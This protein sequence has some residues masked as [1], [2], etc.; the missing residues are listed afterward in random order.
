MP[1]LYSRRLQSP[2]RALAQVPARPATIPATT[3]AATLHPILQAKLRIGAPDDQYE[4]EADRLADQVMHEPRRVHGVPLNSPNGT[5]AVR[6]KCVSCASSDTALCPE[7]EEELQRQVSPLMARKP[8]GGAVQSVPQIVNNVLSSNGQPLEAATRAYFEGRFGHD[9]STTRVHADAR[10][11]ESARAVGARAYTVGPHVVFG[12]GEYT[13]ETPAGMRLL[14]HELTHV[15]QQQGAQMEASGVMQRSPSVCTEKFPQEDKIFGGE[16]TKET[17]G[18]RPLKL[19]STGQADPTTVN[20]F[21]ATGLRGYPELQQIL[22]D[23]NLNFDIKS[24][25]DAKDCSPGSGLRFAYDPVANKIGLEAVEFCQKGDYLYFKFVCVAPPV[26][27]EVGQQLVIKEQENSVQVFDPTGTRLG[28]GYIQSGYIVMKIRTE[29]TSVTGGGVFD[30]IYDKLKAKG[31]TIKGVAGVWTSEPG[32]EKNLADFNKAIAA[33]ESPKVAAQQKTFTG[34]MCE[35]RGLVPKEIYVEPWVPEGFPIDNI[36]APIT[37][38][39]FTS[40][41]VYFE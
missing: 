17:L 27:G 38:G 30:L 36:E 18:K 34:H 1:F 8:A 28:D 35:K 22:R 10:A 4:R 2:T 19:A 40:V 23:N 25:L 41:N 29:G 9:F 21:H 26:G 11:A 32:Y 14:A 20:G 24:P 12:T 15:V 39:P 7:C 5:S 6:R 16:A 33:H 3:L 31:G 37:A 13:L